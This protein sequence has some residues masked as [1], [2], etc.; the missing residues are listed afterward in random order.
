M[1]M[2]VK[3]A[4]KTPMTLSRSKMP[5]RKSARRTRRARRRA[6]SIKLTTPLGK[7]RRRKTLKTSN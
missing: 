4:S 5:R 6:R 2:L 1:M 3:R 7:P